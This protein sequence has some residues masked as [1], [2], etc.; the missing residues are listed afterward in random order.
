MEV[1]EAIEYLEE[2]MEEQFD[3]FGYHE[4]ATEGVRDLLK[5][6]EAENKAY[7]GM[8]GELKIDILRVKSDYWE[9]TFEDVLN[10][11][12]V[13]ETKYLGGKMIEGMEKAINQLNDNMFTDAILESL[14]IK[15]FMQADLNQ[16]KD[17]IEKI[18]K[19]ENMLR[20]LIKSDDKQLINN[21][22]D[23]VY[24]PNE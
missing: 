22:G 6:L 13:Y 15:N 24:E 2:L 3:E 5:T 12:K 4:I 1:K 8:W 16:H 17:H 19:L 14:S 7:R 20:E 18:A 21:E 11:I 23:Y 9:T 10:N